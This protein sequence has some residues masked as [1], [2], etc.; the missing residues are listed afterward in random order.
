MVAS[1]TDDMKILIRSFVPEQIKRTTA[2]LRVQAEFRMYR[3]KN[4]LTRFRLL[5]FA[6]EVLKIQSLRDSASSSCEIWLQG[7]GCKQPKKLD[8]LMR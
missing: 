2:S 1:H 5:P 6:V 3:V 7:Q 4:L 8:T